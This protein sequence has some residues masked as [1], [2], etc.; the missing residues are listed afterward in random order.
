MSN[1]KILHLEDSLKDSELI[2]S[3]I[4]SGEIEHTYYLADNENDFINI[5][6]TENIDIIL[7][8]YSLPDYNGNDALKFSKEKCS[9][10]PFIFISGAMGEDRAIDAMLNGATDYVLKNKLERL[11]PAIKRAL[12]EQK[13]EIE[14]N[15]ANL[16]LKAKNEEIEAQNKKYIQIN[17]ELAYY[18]EEKEKRAAELIIANKELAFQNE[19][20]GKR[21]AELIIANKELTFQNK[22]KEKRAVELIIANKELLFQNEEKEKRAAELVL[23]NKELMFQNKEKEN[24]AN[25]LIIADKELVFQNEEKG[26]RADE[27]IIADKELV[28]Q[29]EEKEKR[30]AELVLA[31]KELVFQN[32]EKEN[33]A[34]ELIIANKELIFQNIEKEKRA[35]ELIIADKELVFQN[36]EKEKRADELIIAGKEL[37]YQNKEKVKRAN[38]LIIANKELIFQNKEKEKRAAELIIANKELAFQNDEKEK[39]ANELI[40]ANKELIFQNEEKEKRAAELIIAKENA[41]ESDKLKTAFLQNMSHEIRTPLNGIIGFSALL[42][43]DDVSKEEIKEYTSLINQSGKRLIEIVNNVLDI[44]KIQTGQIKI[45]KKTINLK[46]I[47]NDLITFFSPIANI[48][49]I[50]LNYHNQTD[51]NITLFSDEA[52]LH[53][54]LVN[55]INNALKFTKTGNVDFGFEVKDKV[56]QFYVKDTG[57]GIA[58]ELYDKIFERFIQA[59]R[60]M[61]KNYEGAGLGLAISKGL[62]DILGGKIWVESEVGKGSVFFFTL[63]ADKVVL[64]SEKGLNHSKKSLKLT[65]GKILIAE[66]DWISFQYMRKLFEKS[67][68]TILHAENGEQAVELVKNNIDIDLIL[69]DI[70]MPVMDGIEATKL[71]KQLRPHLP[72]FAQTAYAFS[73][74]KTKILAVGCDEYLSKPLDSIELNGLINKYLK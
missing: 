72:V 38:E 44:S 49:K 15:Q 26:K 65:H 55:L 2:Q 45:A 13:L 1:I 36:E 23:A 54:I 42:N 61:A 16:N 4:E 43:Y 69:M 29:N 32:K 20:K 37:S 63:P 31:N 7:S 68:I 47:F 21:A 19:E 25:E 57:I 51:E 62:V 66:D 73:E 30:A 46:S 70:R 52:K 9:L 41:E 39:R 40:I 12:R 6:E 14:R 33:R 56:V 53:Q 59:E 60:S 67:D 5:L 71:I 34:A 17:K 48:K 74:E 64:P 3:I 22:E 10:I 28:F 8:D 24:R 11:V 18:S 27:L 58:K 35:D 50:N